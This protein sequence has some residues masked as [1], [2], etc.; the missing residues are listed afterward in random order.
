MIE[1][2]AIIGATASIIGLLLP[3]KGWKAKLTHVIYGL[4]IVL[5]S[6]GYINYDRKLDRIDAIERSAKRLLE[7]RRHNF[8]NAGYI[9]AVLTLLE[10]YQNLYP[11]A[12]ARAKEICAAHDCN[13][14][15]YKKE[16][17][18]ALQHSWGL[19]ELASQM[20]GILQGLIATNK[21]S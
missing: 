15:E 20:D 2:L 13:M 1:S 11:D 3:A 6:I 14:S 18:E 17:V 8:T 10:K 9:Q 7:G 16:G 19:I 21:D 4:V 5:L 12:Y